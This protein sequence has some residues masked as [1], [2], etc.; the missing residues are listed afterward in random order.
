MPDSPSLIFLHGVGDGDVEDGWREVLS[1]ALQQL[2]YPGL[3]GTHV[4]AP[5]YAHAL[6]G[7]DY[8]LPVPDPTLKRLSRDDERKNRRDFEHRMSAME[9]RLGH[10]DPGKML[11][12]V[13]P[14]IGAAVATPPFVQARNYLTKREIRAQVLRRILDALPPSGKIVI[15]AHSLGSV[16][17]ADLVPRLPTQIEV[18]GMVTI[19]SP[20][21][22]GA[23]DVEGLRTSL[24]E[25]PPSLAWWVNFWN[26]PDLVAAHRGVSSVFPWMID[27]RIDSKTMLLPAHACAT[28]LANE[29]VAAAIGYALFGSLSKEIAPANKD[30]DAILDPAEQMALLA[31]RYANLLK[32]RLKGEQ[33]ARFDGALRHVQA[34][35]VEDFIARASGENRA[36]PT[37]MTNLAFDFSDPL[38]PL[39]EPQPAHH[40][41]R[42]DSIV[43][44]TVL[45]SENVIRPFEIEIGTDKRRE[46]MEDLT[47]EMGLTSQFGA[48]VFDAQSEARRALGGGFKVNLVKLGALGVG[49]TAIV[50][51]TGGLALAAG[52]G[53]AGAAALTSAL[54]A[55]GPGGMMG[56]LL[57][58]GALLTA[59]G[60]GVAFGLAGASTTAAALEAIIERRLAAEILR[61]KQG[62][63]PD[64]DV[65]AVLT[66][67]E[68]QVRRDHERLDE[69]SDSDAPSLK[70]LRRKIETVERALTYLRENDLEPS[71][72]DKTQP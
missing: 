17:A 23:F 32:S 1:Q 11:L 61:K 34:A 40:L 51:A 19:G 44:L 12:N 7:T 67:I 53:L 21:A 43:L 72:D 70:D 33:R 42:E 62:L 50:I 39:P 6:R 63:K 38:S 59:G 18:V 37:A 3:S 2:D 26:E 48:Q 65:W 56:G 57:T 31:L 68:R 28:Y 10:H 49:A 45:A 22:H 29:T 35:V 47:A 66:E 24:R 46:A 60:G 41:S 25:P 58:A 27:L 5:K 54:A 55:F 64:P 8:K 4:I 16:I 71:P 14:L 36:L 30:V 69:L 15:V 52:A 20:L 13:N 9:F